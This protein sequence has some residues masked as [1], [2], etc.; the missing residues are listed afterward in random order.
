MACEPC[1]SSAQL[2][3]PIWLIALA[4][5]EA[6]PEPATT[7]NVGNTTCG[8]FWVFSVVNGR[9]DWPAPMPTA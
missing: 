7:A 6:V 8:V 4:P 5:A 2:N 3:E 9:S 1:T